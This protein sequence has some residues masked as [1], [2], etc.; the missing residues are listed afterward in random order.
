M[1]IVIHG[2]TDYCANV[3]TIIIIIIAG[4]S[5]IKRTY[6][7]AFLSFQTVQETAPDNL[8]FILQ[9]NLSGYSTVDEEAKIWFRHKLYWSSQHNEF[10]G[11]M[12]MTTWKPSA[13]GPFRLL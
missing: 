1:L 5:K 13:L 9:N 3:G 10:N 11:F 7:P 4:Y 6:M 8:F 2:R 12:T